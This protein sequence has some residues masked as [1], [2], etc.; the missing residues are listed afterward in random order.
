[1]QLPSG[2][3]C[4][5]EERVMQLFRT[6]NGALGRKKESRKRN[7][8]FHLPAAI[9]CSPSLRL[10]QT[11]S[12][13]VTLGDVYDKHCE[14]TGVT[15]EDPILVA[16]EKVKKVL[17]EFK[18]SFG[19][20]PTKAEYLTLKKEILDEV[21]LK[22]IPEDILT[23]YMIRT[24]EGPSELWRMRKQFALQIASTSFMTYVFCLTSRLPSRFHLSRATGQIA[25][26]ELLPGVA[27]QAPI[28]ASND[29][30]P[31][32]FTPNMQ[33]FLGPIFTEGI[34]TSGIMA[35]GR[36][37]TEPEFD[38]EQQL[39]LFARD[40]VMNWLQGRGKPWTLDIS[41][42][43]NVAANIDGVVKR[44][45]T[46]ACKIEREQA[47]QNPLGPG[48]PPVVQT[49]TNLISMAT[50]PV[51]LIKMSEIYNPWF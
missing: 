38:L 17:R 49:V 26:S 24:M 44:A 50:N 28:F 15:R 34:L 7:L 20:T 29:T 32:R 33:H 16:G 9:S 5:R 25:M 13:Y 10:L 22:I 45:E 31:F 35:I 6:F 1:V 27:N 46:M 19:R 18:Q 40:E 2:R 47:A 8:A 4:R 11:D 14:E 48:Q 3:H 36:C 51:Q 12:S 21:V 41:Y 23:R 42:R 30:V 43:S 39:C 37:L